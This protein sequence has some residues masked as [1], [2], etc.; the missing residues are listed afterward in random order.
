MGQ[1]LLLILNLRLDDVAARHEAKAAEKAA[2]DG[3]PL[4]TLHG[5]PTGIK[6]LEETKDLL[7]TYGSP[8]YR[9]YVP[10]YDNVMVGRVRAA[11]AVVV[12]DAATIEVG[13]SS[14][15]PRVTNPA[16]SSPAP[17]RPTS[18]RSATRCASARSW[19]GRAATSAC[20]PFSPGVR[21]LSI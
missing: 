6:D 21:S 4:G 20:F 17:R 5:L 13:L 18:I 12:A 16:P 9:D 3:E 7:T 10:T 15:R 11:G 8:L 19:S 14:T 2:R 1:L